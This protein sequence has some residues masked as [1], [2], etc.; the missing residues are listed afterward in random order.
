MTRFILVQD[1]DT[2]EFQG[3]GE[4]DRQE[5][6]RKEKRRGEDHQGQD[7]DQ[8][9]AQEDDGREK[10]GRQDR[11]QIRRHRVGQV[12]VLIDPMNIGPAIVRMMARR[13]A[14]PCA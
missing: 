4:V 10:A 12:A 14:E 13:D 7:R 2:E 11:H 5:C 8:G 1:P 3:A 6:G 9:E